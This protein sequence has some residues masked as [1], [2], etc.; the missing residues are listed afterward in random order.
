MSRHL[1]AVLLN[2]ALAT[3]ANAASL[4]GNARLGVIDAI[5]PHLSAGFGAA[6][7]AAKAP[8]IRDEWKLGTVA[9]EQAI[10]QLDALGYHAA[11]ASLPASLADTVRLGGAVKVNGPDVRLDTAFARSLARWLKEQNLDGVVVL[12]TLSRPLAKDAP[13][14]SGY[15][16]A[17]RGDTPVAYANLAPLLISGAP[18]T[19]VGAP[20]CL[21][22]T[23]VD[24][25]LIA[26]PKKLADLAPLGPTLK[27]VLRKSVDGALIRS[28][29]MQGDAACE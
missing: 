9:Q 29:V 3:G 20:T 8:T 10:K 6:A 2:L 7:N 4:P 12:R 15:G 16:I 17:R 18:P 26:T 1:A 23:P 25:S 13:A 5:A 22:A 11:A 24:A 28:G 19:I 14:Q 27:D 21:V